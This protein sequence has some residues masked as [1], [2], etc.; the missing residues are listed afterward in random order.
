MGEVVQLRGYRFEEEVSVRAVKADAMIPVEFG[1]GMTDRQQ[2]LKKLAESGI[3]RVAVH[4]LQAQP[5]SSLVMMS[6]QDAIWFNKKL[7]ANEEL[8]DS[9]IADRIDLIQMLENSNPAVLD[10]MW[11]SCTTLHSEVPR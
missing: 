2:C 3:R 5:G 4:Q 8:S 10:A 9:E 6:L 1:T 11:K 7:L